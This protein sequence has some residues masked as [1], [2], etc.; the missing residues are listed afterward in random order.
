MNAKRIVTLHWYDDYSFSGS[1]KNSQGQTI[2]A[3]FE[4]EEESHRLSME[5]QIGDEF[6][7][8]I[9]SDTTF[10]QIARITKG[11]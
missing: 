10:K 9:V 5:A 8:E 4:W 2:Y 7:A 6:V 1:F 11:V 3:D